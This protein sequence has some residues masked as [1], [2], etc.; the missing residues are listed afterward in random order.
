MMGNRISIISFFVL[1]FAFP[2]VSGQSLGDIA[3]KNQA[4]KAAAKTNPV[5]VLELQGR[6]MQE[7]PDQI[8][9]QDDKDLKKAGDGVWRASANAKELEAN[10]LASKNSRVLGN[11]YAGDIQFPHREEWEGRLYARKEALISALRELIKATRSKVGVP[12][13]KQLN[14]DY[15][16]ALTNVQIARSRFS[17]IQSEG[18]SL[19]ASWKNNP[20]SWSCG[21]VGCYAPCRMYIDCR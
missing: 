17:A 21:N 14:D 16:D 4:D 10:A 6:P 1:L 15:E 20:Q 11:E 12:A 8:P 18:A 7:T 13:T 9:E 5:R 19:A 3:R 2:S